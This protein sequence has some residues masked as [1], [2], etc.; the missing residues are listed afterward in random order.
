MIFRALSGLIAFA[1]GVVATIGTWIM[2]LC[3]VGAVILC[4]V[5]IAG[6][7]H[8]PYL[9]WAIV[10]YTVLG[11]VFIGLMAVVAFIAAVFAQK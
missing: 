9:L 5:Q 6:L 2:G 10:G 7:V 11:W 3:T 8:T 4:F 1:C